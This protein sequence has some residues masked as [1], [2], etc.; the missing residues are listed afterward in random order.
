MDYSSCIY[1]YFYVYVYEIWD[2]MK[3]ERGVKGKE[4]VS[5]IRDC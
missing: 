3:D 2:A 1:M 4:N 5:D